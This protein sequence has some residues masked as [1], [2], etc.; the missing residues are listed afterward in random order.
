MLDRILSWIADWISSQSIEV[1]SITATIP[2]NAQDVYVDAVIPSGY[3]FL[4][5][6]NF[7]T[8]GWIGSLETGYTT[9]SKRIRIWATTSSAVNRKIRCNYLIIRKLGG[10]LRNPAIT[11]LSAI[12]NKIGGGVD[13]GQNI[14]IHSRNT[15]SADKSAVRKRNNNKNVRLQDNINGSNNHRIHFRLL[16]SRIYAWMVRISLSRNR[17]QP[18]NKLLACSNTESKRPEW[19]NKSLGVV[20]KKSASLISERGCLSC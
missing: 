3:K 5:W 17:K 4:S 9:D 2:A 12:L 15:L 6:T 18:D 11:T 7:G 16:D 14:V 1:R 8:D 19:R 10:V 13:V 20:R